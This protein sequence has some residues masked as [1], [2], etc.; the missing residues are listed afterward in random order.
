MGRGIVGQRWSTRVRAAI[1]L[2]LLLAFGLSA[3][4]ALTVATARPASAH[5]FVQESA[6][7]DGAVA[8]D[9]PERAYF[10]YNEAVTL[11]DSSLQLLD[12]MGKRIPIEAAT[13]FNGAANTAT[14]PLP[15][16]LADGTYV[17]AWRVTSADSHIVSGA[18]QF[19]VG[20]PS[21]IVSDQRPSDT[22]PALFQ[23]LG[24]GLAFLGMA[25]ALGGLAFLWVLWPAGHNDRRARATVWA[26]L[27]AL[28]A[29]TAVVFLTYG[30][31]ATGEPLTRALSSSMVRVTMGIT[32]GPLLLLRLALVAVLV[33]AFVVAGRRGRLERGAKALGG[34]C[35]LALPL[36]WAL[37]DHARTGMQVWLALPAT[38]VHLLAMSLWLGGVVV[39]VIA[40]LSRRGADSPGRTASLSSALPRFSTMAQACFVA[41]AVTG[42]YLSWRQVGTLPALVATTYGQLLLVKLAVVLAV[43]ALASGARAFVR[44]RH[45]QATGHPEG[46]P[47]SE[48]GSAQAASAA[49]VQ[50]SKALR[51]LRRTVGG[52]VVLGIAVIA[53]TAALVNTAPART[54]YTPAFHTDR[55]IPV[56]DGA[57]SAMEGGRIQVDIKPARTGANIVDI[58]LTSASG[59]LLRVQEVTG[60]LAPANGSVGAIPVEIASGEPGHYVATAV[61]IPF[62]GRWVLRLDLR[63][64]EFDEVPVP[65][66]FTVR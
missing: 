24:R 56:T 50:A 41:L 51:R 31:L 16:D 36:T 40:V 33:A 62:P 22:A 42:V 45:A 46:A 27:A 48:P 35:A 12:A 38:L 64:S 63:T 30:P 21:A 5:A 65:V 6:P 39:L 17:I 15:R 4:A 54:S 7:V 8:D 52:E 44:R 60:L 55:K 10:R 18:I 28:F 53:V 29:G 59:D 37:A 43:V 25:I 11:T 32:L 47:D 34:L 23:G 9:P 49:D 20:A 58:F 61:S 57:A 66:E 3:T 19:S 13:H 26:G 2:A 14:A 1:S